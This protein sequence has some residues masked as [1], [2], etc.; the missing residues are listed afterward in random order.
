MSLHYLLCSVALLNCHSQWFFAEYMFPFLKGFFN[1]LCMTCRRRNNSDCI[2][3]VAI[4]HSIKIG[5]NIFYL[6]TGSYPFQ[7]FL[8]HI[9]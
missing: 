2:N 4:Q 5:I 7:P 6:Q 1:L 8:I 9:T 3:L